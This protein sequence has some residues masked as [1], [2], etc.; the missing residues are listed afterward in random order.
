MKNNLKKLLVLA[1]VAT[2]ANTVVVAGNE[3]DKTSYFTKGKDYV[4]DHKTGTILLGASA[5]AGITALV[6]N[7]RNKTRGLTNNQAKYA[8][9]TAAV[10]AALG[11]AELAFDLTGKAGFGVKKTQAALK[12]IEALDNVTVHTANAKDKKK[13]VTAE[14]KQKLET[15]RTN[16]LLALATVKAEEIAKEKLTAEQTALLLAASLKLSD[17]DQLKV[18]SLKTLLAKP[19][20]AKPEVAKPEVA[21]PEAPEAPKANQAPAQA[22]EAPKQEQSQAPEAPKAPK[23]E[24]SQAPEAPKAQA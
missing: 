12:S 21:K 22:P 8:A 10:L 6:V 17:A 5:V 19:E 14:Q 9:I 18:A 4:M 11:G 23:Q 2:F 15:A 7:R 1:T 20:V 3:G 13:K 16:A 24:Q